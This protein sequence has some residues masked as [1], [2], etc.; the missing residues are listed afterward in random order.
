MFIFVNET[1]LIL[2]EHQSR[3]LKGLSVI[4]LDGQ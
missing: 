4:I 3:D 1:S 2:V